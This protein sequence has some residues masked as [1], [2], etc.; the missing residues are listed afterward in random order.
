MGKSTGDGGFS[1]AT[2]DYRRANG[3]TLFIQQLRSGSERWLSIFPASWAWGDRQLTQR[4]RE[5]ETTE[6]TTATATATTTAI[7]TA[8]AATTER[9]GDILGNDSNP[10][11]IAGVRSPTII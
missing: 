10:W 1:I 2:L 9:A 11:G 3:G 5:T 8:T 6:T 7:A 4:E